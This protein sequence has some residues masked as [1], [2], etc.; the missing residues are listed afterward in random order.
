MSEYAE[1][2]KD[3]RQAAMDQLEITRK[4]AENQSLF[5][6]EVIAGQ[7]AIRAMQPSTDELL[8]TILGNRP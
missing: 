8:K 4:I 6:Q 5:A 7:A 2:L 3:E 1:M